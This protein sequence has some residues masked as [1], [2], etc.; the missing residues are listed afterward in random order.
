MRVETDHTMDWK[1]VEIIDQDES[2][3]GLKINEM[4]H[5]LGKDRSLNRQLKATNANFNVKTFIIAAHPM[6]Q[7]EIM[8]PM[9]RNTN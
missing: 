5:I 3:S 6:L 2:E 7:R 1:G 9:H 4:I 8:G